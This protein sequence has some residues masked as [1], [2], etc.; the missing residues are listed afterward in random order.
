MRIKLLMTLMLMASTM[1]GQKTLTLEDVMPGGNNWYNLQPE[2][3]FTVW[4]ANTP[5][6]TTADEVKNL[7]TGETIVTVVSMP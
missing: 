7:V 5:L 3:R 4:W 2:N 1:M 6:E